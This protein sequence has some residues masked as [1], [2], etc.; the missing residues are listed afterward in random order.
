M[1]IAHTKDGKNFVGETDCQ[2]L[3]T[4]LINTARY[5]KERADVFDAGEAAEL[6]GLLHDIGKYSDAFQERIRGKAIF[7]PHAMAGAII[8]SKN[9]D[10]LA[11]LYGIVVGSHHTGLSDYGTKIDNDNSTYCGKLN[12]HVE[13]QLPYES[14]L[15]LPDQITHKSLKQC[16]DDVAFQ[17]AMY[18]RML[19]SVLVDSDFTD[20]EEFCTDIKRKVDFPTIGELFTALMKSM[21]QSSGCKVDKIRAEILND[22]LCA[23]E[24]AQGLFSLTA[25]TGGGKTLSTLAFALKHAQIH[26]LRRVIYVIPYTSIIEQNAKVFCEK[27]GVG[28]V[29][30]HHCNFELNTDEDTNNRQA[31][32]AS[33]NWDI[34]VI[35]TTNVQFFESLFAS[36]TSKS[37]KVHN[38]AGSV[39]IFDEAQM[40]PSDYLSPCM[41]II[42]ELVSNYNMTAVLCSAT[43]PLVQK[44][45]Y[46]DIK[47]V[48][49]SANPTELS[50]K[51]KRVEFRFAGKKS[52]SELVDELSYLRSALVI[53]NSRKHAFTLYNLAK[54]V[55]S[56]GSLFYLSTLLTPNHRSAK[57]A[58][59]KRRLKENLPVV[60]I[61]TQL[62]EAGVDVDFPIVYRSIAGIDSIIQA[63]GRANREG[64]MANLGE[65]IIFESTDNPTPR[66]LQNTVSIAKETISVCGDNAFGLEGIKKYFEL[67]YNSLERDDEMDKKGILTE[68]EMSRGEIT[69]MNFETVAKNFKLIEDNTHDI[70]IPCD[71]SEESNHLINK[72]R[73]N[74][75]TRKM[76]RQLQ[77]YTVNIYDKEYKQLRDDNVIE[78]IN[79]IAVLIAPKY[80]SYETGL[81]I[82]TDEN[83]NAESYWN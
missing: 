25:P 35:V 37:R 71:D 48:E 65:V 23:A 20:T 34:P 32:W 5:A 83:K 4:H 28:N 43:Q 66:A 12:N 27:L 60:V 77:K 61:S 78:I 31:K 9:H 41:A 42:S 11:R 81:D 14:E 47:T 44:Y 50:E 33:E 64:K 39:V 8:L 76:F 1:H 69:K 74:N 68:F 36:K 17:I 38:I 40:L 52:D 26:K 46:D 51:L 7:A 18:L 73:Q 70:V 22:C 53:V 19:F 55:I 6:I 63:G 16:K 49:I 72:L 79:N 82:F 45:A 15:T 59:I 29:L 30:E 62:I 75:F 10:D 80:Y 67:F 2:L 54:N 3:V 56:Q 57:I 24:N 13:I 58:E 21:P